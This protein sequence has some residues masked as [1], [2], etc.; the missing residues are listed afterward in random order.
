MPYRDSEYSG[1]PTIRYYPLAV[2]MVAFCFSSPTK[3]HCNPV[4]PG[5]IAL[6]THAAGVS[7]FLVNRHQLLLR[8]IFRKKDILVHLHQV[9]SYIISA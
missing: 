4:R 7:P 6:R 3:E 8:L 1:T 5:G 2:S 9:I